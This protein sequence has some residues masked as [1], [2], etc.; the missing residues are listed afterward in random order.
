MKQIYKPRPVLI[1]LI[2][3]EHFNSLHTNT[4]K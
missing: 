3:S 1:N 2:H 4:V